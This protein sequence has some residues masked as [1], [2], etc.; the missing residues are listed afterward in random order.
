MAFRLLFLI[1][2]FSS[3]VSW[4]MTQQ[5]QIHHG[6]T[7]LDSNGYN[8]INDTIP[9]IIS[10]SLRTATSGP[11]HS[12]V[13]NHWRF[14]NQAGLDFSS[15]S[16]V[17]VSSPMKAFEYATA[18]SDQNGNLLFFTNGGGINVGTQYPGGV[19]NRNNQLM[20]N[21]TLTPNDIGC[22]SSINNALI[23]PDPGDTSEYYVFVQSC[24]EEGYSPGLA[25][26]KVDMDLDNGLG[27]VSLKNQFLTFT[28]SES[29]AGIRHCNGT[30]YWLLVGNEMPNEMNIYLINSNGVSQTPVVNYPVSSTMRPSRLK[31]SPDGSRL[32]CVFYS[33]AVGGIITHIYQFN[34]ATGSLTFETA[35]PTPIYFGSGAEFS[36]NGRFLYLWGF[37]TQPPNTYLFQFDLF[38]AQP[39]TSGYIQTDTLLGLNRPHGIQCGPDG[40]IYLSRGNYS[41]LDAIPNP[42]QAQAS[43]QPNAVTLTQGAVANYGLF[44]GLG[45]STYDPTP[46]I[47]GPIVLCTGTQGEYDLHFDSCQTNGILWEYR[48]GGTLVSS[49]DSQAI[50]LAGTVGM[51]TLIVTKMADCSTL[52]DTL[53]IEVISDDLPDLGADTMICEDS[54]VISPG[55]GFTSY[56]WQ[57]NSTD[58]IFTVYAPGTYYVET[59]GPC[60]N[61]GVDSIT[62][63]PCVGV[64]DHDW[65]P[66]LTVIPNPNQGMFRLEANFSKWI[67]ELEVSVVD[68]MGKEVLKRY[69]HVDGHRLSENIKLAGLPPGLYFLQVRHDNDFQRRTFLV[70]E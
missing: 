36:P 54:I 62:V 48:G 35:L 29:M 23:I 16:P 13:T 27:D 20:P 68:A 37:E 4:G 21:G 24:S 11:C 10:P 59:I 7:V 63:L 58:S 61:R 57:D 42:N 67:E 33:T 38:A 5:V 43:V 39:A 32:A 15:G 30:D 6:M 51:D 64:L 41:A 52:F 17:Q 49:V 12:K 28:H 69:L 50:V 56:T 40:K 22:T 47:M 70:V 19:W 65:H 26:H 2:L 8:S 25:Y 14:G 9:E 31:F 45:E 3:T 66:E 44:A 46:E 1:S 18:V 53:L 60:G 55:G 34:S